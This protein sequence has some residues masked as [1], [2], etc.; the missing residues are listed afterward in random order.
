[1]EVAE[2]S[3]AQR[4]EDFFLFLREYPEKFFLGPSFASPREIKIEV[5]E[6]F[7]GQ[8]QNKFF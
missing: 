8:P 6:V 2:I 1:M 3:C 7:L 4:L 5:G